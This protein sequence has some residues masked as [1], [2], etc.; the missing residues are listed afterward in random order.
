MKSALINYPS[1]LYS[2]L[3]GTTLPDSM[4]SFQLGRRSKQ[5]GGADEIPFIY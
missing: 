5:E 1:C 4:H 3:S 2:F